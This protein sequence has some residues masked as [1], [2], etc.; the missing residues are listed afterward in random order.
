MTRKQRRLGFVAAGA[1]IL[2]AAAALTFSALGENM[3]F[4]HSPSDIV[5]KSVA[6]GERIRLGGL[7][8]EGS[9]QESGDAVTVFVVTDFQSRIPVV[10][11]GILPDLFRENQGVV[12]E[13]VLTGDGDFIADTVLAKHDETY[14]PPEV[15]EALQKRG[16]WQGEGATAPHAQT[17]G[18]GAYP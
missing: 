14:M 10:Y 1:I 12:A 8:E 6:P 3:V 18:E 5:E 11:E 9:V 2:G 13:G 15:A 4:F 7:V 17:Y 16:D